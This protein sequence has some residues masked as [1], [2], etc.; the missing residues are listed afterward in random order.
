MKLLAISKAL[1]RGANALF[2]QTVFGPG[3]VNLFQDKVPVGEHDDPAHTASHAPQQVV[4]V[5]GRSGRQF[6]V[7]GPR[8]LLAPSGHAAVESGRAFRT[9]GVARFAIVPGHGS[10]K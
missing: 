5:G 2:Y 3:T 1:E 6:V 4:D 10:S 7:R 8:Q 9:D